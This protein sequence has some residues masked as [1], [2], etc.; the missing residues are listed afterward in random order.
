[1]KEKRKRPEKNFIMGKYVF[2]LQPIYYGCVDNNIMETLFLS[3]LLSFYGF[4]IAKFVR[5]E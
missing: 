1:M 4:V 3:T 2:N 5:S